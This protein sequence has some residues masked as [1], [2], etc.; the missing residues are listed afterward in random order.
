MI[1][2]KLYGRSLAFGNNDKVITEYVYADVSEGRLYN[3]QGVAC[4]AFCSPLFL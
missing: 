2:D 4:V 3:V 1:D